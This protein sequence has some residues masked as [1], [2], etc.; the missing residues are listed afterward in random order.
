[1]DPWPLSLWYPRNLA[2]G[3]LIIPVL[4]IFPR[5]CLERCLRGLDILAS[6]RNCLPDQGALLESGLFSPCL[7]ILH[8]CSICLLPN[9]VYGS[10][11]FAR[12]SSQAQARKPFSSLFPGRSAT[13]CHACIR[14]EETLRT[15]HGWDNLV[16]LKTKR[17]SRESARELDHSFVEHIAPDVATVMYGRVGIVAK[18]PVHFDT[19][20]SDGDVNSV[21]R[22]RLQR[23]TNIGLVHPIGTRRSAC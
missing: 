17:E 19:Q 3:V 8:M 18:S 7:A 23:R 4:C 22:Q 6:M 1:M 15:I 10:I 9:M 20:R 11:L 21:D 2:L 14:P 12:H 5:C 13:F 16:R